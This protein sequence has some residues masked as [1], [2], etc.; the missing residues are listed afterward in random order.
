MAIK[1]DYYAWNDGR[2]YGTDRESALGAGRYDA[3]GD[4]AGYDV[5]QAKSQYSLAY[6]ESSNDSG[7]LASPT[8]A[9]C[10]R[11]YYVG[12]EAAKRTERS[13]EP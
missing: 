8:C 7:Q 1:R 11:N 10:P 13:S 12:H 3:F 2:C 4:I 6:S 5:R 9:Q